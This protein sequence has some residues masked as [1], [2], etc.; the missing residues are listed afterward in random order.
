VKLP[1]FKDFQ[2]F[3]ELRKKIGTEEFGYFELFD[4]AIHLTGSE[5]STLENPGILLKADEF[6]V[7]PDK[8]LA[9]K[10]SRVLVYIPDEAWYRKHREYPS[11]HL[12]WCSQL[13]AQLVGHSMLEYLVTTKV[14]DDY[15]L[16]KIRSNGEV[17]LSEHGLVVCK[18]CLHTLR[19]RN[20]DEFR[21]RRRGH[22]QKVLNDFSLQD[23]YRFYQQ[24]PLSFA[25]SALK[26]KKE[27]AER[28]PVDDSSLDA[29][30]SL[31]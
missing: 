25:K 22:S 7:L 6:R 11:Y 2:A 26:E 19:Y 10:N 14:S 24:Y 20:Y 4:P 12:A 21:N 28:K 16:L 13:E 17:S 31:D 30:S 23:F 15:K 27:R 5:R 1:D 3:N 29:E 8:T 9:I 18:H